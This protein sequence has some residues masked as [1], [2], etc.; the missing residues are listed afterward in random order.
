[1]NGLP[2]LAQSIQSQ[3]RGDDSMLVHMA[4]EEVAGLRALA[5]AQGTDN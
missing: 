2:A 3:G 4:P 1:M 5:R